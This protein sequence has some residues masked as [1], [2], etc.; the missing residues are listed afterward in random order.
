VNRGYLLTRAHWCDG[1]AWQATCAGKLMRRCFAELTDDLADLIESVRET[2]LGRGIV[3]EMRVDPGRYLWPLFA[4]LHAHV[5]PVRRV[6]TD[7]VLW[8]DPATE[9]GSV[10]TVWLRG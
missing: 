4:W 1:I 2:D 6:E 5:G 9:S 8:G 10:R 3:V 7:A